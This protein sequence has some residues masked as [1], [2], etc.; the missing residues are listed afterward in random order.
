MTDAPLVQLL[1]STGKP[2]DF[3]VSGNPRTYESMTKPAGLREIA[4]YADGVASEQELDRAPGCGRPL[5]RADE[6]RR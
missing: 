3:V 1:N 2:Y 5:A 6:L 4:R